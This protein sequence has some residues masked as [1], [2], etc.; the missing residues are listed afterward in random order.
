MGEVIQQNMQLMVELSDQSAGKA[1]KTL[2]H[3]QAVAISAEHLQDSIL[4]L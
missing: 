4:H 3:S 2:E 1:T